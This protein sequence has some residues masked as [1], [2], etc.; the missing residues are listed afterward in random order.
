ME[1]S[2]FHKEGNESNFLRDRDKLLNILQHSPKQNHL[3]PPQNQSTT[4]TTQVQSTTYTTQITQP[5]HSG[6]Q[7]YSQATPYQTYTLPSQNIHNSVASTTQ[8][9]YRNPPVQVKHAQPI[10]STDPSS[11]QIHPTSSSLTAYSNYPSYYNLQPSNQN[12]SP[13]SSPNPSS[14]PALNPIPSLNPTLSYPVQRDNNYGQQNREQ[15]DIER[16]ENH[17]FNLLFNK[18]D[19]LYPA[20]P[21]FFHRNGGNDIDQRYF[22]NLSKQQN[23][24]APTF[25]GTHVEQHYNRLSKNTALPVNNS[26]SFEDDP[27][28]DNLDASCEVKGRILPDAFIKNISDSSINSDRTP[29]TQ[30][31]QTNV[32]IVPSRPPRLPPPPLRASTG[33]PSATANNSIPPALAKDFAPES[34]IQ[35]EN[36]GR[37]PSPDTTHPSFYFYVDK[38]S[39]INSS[40]DHDINIYANDG[41]VIPKKEN[42]NSEHDDNIML[43]HDYEF[44]PTLKNTDINASQSYQT[45]SNETPSSP[46]ELGDKVCY[47][48]DHRKKVKKSKLTRP[49]KKV[50]VSKKNLEKALKVCSVC[51]TTETT[52]WRY[53]KSKELCCNACGLYEQKHS[54]HRPFLSLKEED[55]DVGEGTSSTNSGDH[56]GSNKSCYHCKTTQ[57]TMWRRNKDKK[58]C[59]NACGCYE[60]KHFAKRPI[61]MSLR[62]KQKGLPF[63]RHR[64]N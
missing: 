23:Y 51:K 58:L 17:N 13:N 47:S 18:S 8:P 61:S 27:D 43:Y 55:V 32:T 28:F 14:T 40:V 59:C 30:S 31:K 64:K 57:T 36:V 1:S 35:V 50:T 41:K 9:V 48:L 56:D 16:R 60:R 52:L 29:L 42:A 44:I 2:H 5:T 10:Y 15:K 3:E 33:K 39:T 38:K 53:T 26:S 54:T 20:K 49:M 6:Y 12:P 7:T 62:R 45:N 63:K 4:Y 19:Q 21:S 34:K 11:A 37:D 25:D 22:G 46:D 24:V